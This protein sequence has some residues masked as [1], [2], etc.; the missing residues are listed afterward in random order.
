MKTYG[1]QI[2]D[3]LLVV[4]SHSNRNLDKKILEIK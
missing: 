3:A 4:F 1:Y 2:S